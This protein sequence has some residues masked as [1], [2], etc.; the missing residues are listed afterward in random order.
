[1]LFP[2][3]QLRAPKNCTGN[4]SEA[5]KDWVFP[6]NFNLIYQAPVYAGI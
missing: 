6:F 5:R 3:A 2:Q 4:F 1:M